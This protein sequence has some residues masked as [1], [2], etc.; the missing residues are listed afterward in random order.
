MTKLEE[1]LRT[2]QAPGVIGTRDSFGIGKAFIDER[3]GKVIDNYRSWEKAGYREISEIKSEKVKTLAK[4]KVQ[5][6]KNKPNRKADHRNLQ[7]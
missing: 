4:E 2:G 7:L 1:I 6:I 3:S 5:R